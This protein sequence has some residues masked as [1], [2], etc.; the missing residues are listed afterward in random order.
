M[1]SRVLRAAGLAC[2]VSVAVVLGGEAAG[3]EGACSGNTGAV[4]C[5]P[6]RWCE[7]PAGQC[8]PEA[9]A[10]G[11]CVATPQ[12]CTMIYRPVC[13]CDGRTYGNDCERLGQRVAKKHDGAC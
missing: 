7:P 2:A 12:V 11:I 3:Q 10:A 1:V 9:G 6:G 8:K 4:D 5:G 13:G